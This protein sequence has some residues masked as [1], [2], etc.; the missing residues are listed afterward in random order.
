MV[1]VQR[2]VST[3]RHH[4]LIRDIEP[5]RAVATPDRPV[6]GSRREHKEYLRRNNFVEYGNDLKTGDFSI[7]RD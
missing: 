1:E 4:H 7:K 5:Y 2:D 3:Q 6:I